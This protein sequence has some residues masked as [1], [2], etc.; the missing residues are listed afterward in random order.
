M[1]EVI[2]IG[3]LL[4]WILHSIAEAIRMRLLFKRV[5]RDIQNIELAERIMDRV[6]KQCYVEKN[7]EMFYLYDD[8]TTAFLC[9]GN[10]HEDLAQRLHEQH[11]IQVALVR[12]LDKKNHLWFD[13]GK[14]KSVKVEQ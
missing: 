6:F 12:D 9:Q 5:M 13:H 4:G 1:W 11:D 7:G 10:S 8:V 14:I 3:I 2:L